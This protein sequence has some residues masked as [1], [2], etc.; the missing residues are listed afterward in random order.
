MH[1]CMRHRITVINS[2]QSVGRRESDMTPPS[3]QKRSASVHAAGPGRPGLRRGGGRVPLR[4]QWKGLEK[5]NT[6][7]R[8]RGR[9]EA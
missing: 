2:S 9:A 8:G 5:R 6:D 3:S 4:V 1:R 7:R